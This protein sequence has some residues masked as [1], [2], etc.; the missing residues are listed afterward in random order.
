MPAEERKLKVGKTARVY[1]LSPAKGV[2]FKANL[3][4]LHGYRQLGKYFINQFQALQDLGFAVIVPEALNRFYIEGYSGRVGAS[5]MTKEARE[6]DIQDQIN[7][8]D[9]LHEEFNLSATPLIVLGFSQGGPTACRWLSGSKFNPQPQ[10]LLLN[11]TVFPNDFDF[12]KSELRSLSKEELNK[13]YNYLFTHPDQSLQLDGHADWIGTVE[14]NL[15]LSERRAKEAYDYLIARGIEDSRLI[16][17]YFGEAVP[18]AP[19]ANPDGSDNPQ[20][21]QLNRRCEISI[22]S[23]GTAEIIMKF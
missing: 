9:Q 2:A 1:T 23:E 4:A 21:R 12:D 13:V 7:Y 16:Y 8:L 15:A 6:D 22:K 19:N 10:H 17:Q 20:G 14:Y 5:W 18:V 11:S 3:L